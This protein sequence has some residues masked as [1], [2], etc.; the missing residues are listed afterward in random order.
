MTTLRIGGP[1]ASAAPRRATRAAGGFALP[2]GTAETAGPA[3]SGVAAAGALLGLQEAPARQ[4]RQGAA[5]L[6]RA[7]RTIEA[8]GALQLGLLRGSSGAEPLA[9]LAALAEPGEVPD[10][11]ALAALVQAIA[12]RAK[13]ELA[14]RRA[15]GG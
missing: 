10:D 8:L 7:E 9:R 3:A 1:A 11:P 6:A 15:L 5:A 13:V 12:L 14:R 2:A 4:D